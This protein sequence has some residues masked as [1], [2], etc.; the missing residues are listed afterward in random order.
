MFKPD[1]IHHTPTHRQPQADGFTLIELLVVISIVSLLIALLLPALAKARESADR[2]KCMNNLKQ[3]NISLATYTMDADGEQFPPHHKN[4]S[5]WPYVFRDW[6]L[7]KSNFYRS[8]L[9]DKQV[10]YCPTD[11]HK[12]ISNPSK[13]A[14]YFPG[15]V[16]GKSNTEI[17]YVYFMG[18]DMS[19]SY[20]KNFR[21]GK[22]S[23]VDVLEP[24]RT[25][26]IADTMRFQ[27]YNILG[28][29]NSFGSWNHARGSSMSSLDHGGSMAF[30]DGHVAWIQGPDVLKHDQR[31]RG[32]DKTYVA[33]Q[34]HD[35]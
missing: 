28:Y 23:M 15:R 5:S 19:Y 27:L 9:N 26:A 7:E 13:N 1:K 30:V 17:S 32:G 14:R 20:K 16:P 11:V 6:G 3:I 12:G 33:V 22:V 21:N 31:M 4:N 29:I 24:A 8:Y 34:P 18:Q 10:Y 25:T 2:V 35:F